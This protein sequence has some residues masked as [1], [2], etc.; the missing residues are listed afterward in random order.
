M[1]RWSDTQAASTASDALQ[2]LI[3]AGAAATLWIQAAPH[4]RREVADDVSGVALDS[5]HFIPEER[6][7]E[8]VQAIRA[9]LARLGLPR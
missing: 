1:L 5:G 7:E 8:V 2:L 3:P 4:G 9:F 6:P